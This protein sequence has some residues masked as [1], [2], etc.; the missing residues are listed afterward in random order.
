MEYKS[1]DD[2]NRNLNTVYDSQ[3]LVKG[4]E[5]EIRGQ[6]EA[7]QTTVTLWSIRIPR[8]VLDSKAVTKALVKDYH[9]ILVRKTR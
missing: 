5:L 1:D 8:R 3:R 4:A 7:V 6:T 2:T 9:I